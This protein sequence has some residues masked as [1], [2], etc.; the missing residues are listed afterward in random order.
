MAFIPTMVL[1][2][3]EGTPLVERHPM[4][5]GLA[6]V[7]LGVWGIASGL[8]F[9]LRWQAY[10]DTLKAWCH[11]PIACAILKAPDASFVWISGL[12]TCAVFLVA[13]LDWTNPMTRRPPSRPRTS[14][15]PWIV[16]W[17]ILGTWLFASALWLLIGPFYPVYPTFPAPLPRALI[18]SLV[19]IP[20]MTLG[21][22]L[23]LLHGWG[24]THAP[25]VGA[26]GT[27]EGRH[28]L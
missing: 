27:L 26:G 19:G 21:L 22:G 13:I 9:I 15:A 28:G 11:G 4:F 8:T 7:I 16:A 5:W 20:A 3:E 12:A 6:Q 24:R 18:I 25:G 1:S 17:A 10:I 2:V 23:K 14:T